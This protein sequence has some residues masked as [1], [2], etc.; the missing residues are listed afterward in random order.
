MTATLLASEILEEWALKP[1]VRRRLVW[2]TAMKATTI[3]SATGGKQELAR[4][5]RGGKHA[6]QHGALCP[7]Q[8][9]EEGGVRHLIWA[10]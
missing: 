1:Q 8:G 9:R 10:H 5:E 3:F 4:P 6:Q 2:S 7:L